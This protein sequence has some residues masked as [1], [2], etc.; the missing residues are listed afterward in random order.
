MY[1]LLF[2][3]RFLNNR[4]K[5]KKRTHIN[6]W[7]MFIIRTIYRLW[8]QFIQLYLKIKTLNCWG[9]TLGMYKWSKK[10]NI[11]QKKCD[12]T[13]NYLKFY[14]IG[15]WNYFGTNKDYIWIS[16]ANTHWNNIVNLAG[17]RDRGQN[18][19]FYSSLLVFLKNS[20]TN[21]NLLVSSSSLRKHI[22]NLPILLFPMFPWLTKPKKLS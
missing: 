21:V 5:K 11:H 12:W 13:A 16:T 3:K 19:L 10:W 9:C 17:G 8:Q 20:K 1:Y 7:N 2:P 22:T 15:R 4:K 6:D 14:S 18:R